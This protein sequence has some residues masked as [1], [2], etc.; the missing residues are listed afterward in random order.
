MNKH[1]A[2]ME[3]EKYRRAIRSS[4]SALSSYR[5]LKKQ[6]EIVLRFISGN[7]VFGVVPTGFGKTLAIQSLLRC[8]H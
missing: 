8:L 5:K 2:E 1:V 6:Q 3:L 4:V 7:D